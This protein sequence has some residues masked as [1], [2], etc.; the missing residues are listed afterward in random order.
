MHRIAIDCRFAGTS[1]GLGRYARELV[2]AL[3]QQSVP[4]EYVLLVLP[5]AKNWIATL[6]VSKNWS[7]VE[8]SS[9]HYSLSEHWVIPHMLRK[10]SIERLFSPHCTAPL[11]CPVPFVVTV[12]DLILHA[13]PNAAP[14][15]KRL[16]YRVL[17]RHAVRDAATVITISGFV[18]GEIAQAYG[19]AT[20]Q[21]T[22]VITEGVSEIFRKRNEEEQM[23][24]RKR[25]GIEGPFFLYVGN[26]KE[27]KNV[28]MLLEA[29]ARLPA[30][31]PRL[32]L[33]TGGREAEHLSL[34]P[35]VVRLDGVDDNDL[36]CLYSAA[37]CFVTASSYEGFCLPLAEALTCGCP[38]IAPNRGPMPEVSQGQAHLI[39]L[40]TE[41]LTAALL[42]PP[43]PPSAFDRPL[44]E[45]CA[46]QTSRV[47]MNAL[48]GKKL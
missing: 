31:S 27:H 4:V 37:A 30:S 28:P 3:L 16:G 15:W 10:H 44:W 41:A 45:S 33:V 12:H 25:F 20:L 22:Q 13:F 38:A 9:R 2:S 35:R 34:P 36:A 48:N 7:A 1:S 26:A 32:V 39:E 40:T 29:F 18:A 14:L 42:S 19:S 5:E 8:I 23:R 46:E 24:I 43:S 6:P 47:L 21:R 11:F 17:M